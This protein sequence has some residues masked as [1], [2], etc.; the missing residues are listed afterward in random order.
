MLISGERHRATHQRPSV[1]DG[2]LEGFEMNRVGVWCTDKNYGLEHFKQGAAFIGT[3][4]N[5]IMEST[6]TA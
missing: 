5:T 6:A 4:D 2:G 3:I 1:I